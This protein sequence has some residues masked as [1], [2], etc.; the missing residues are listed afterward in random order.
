MFI[1]Y[2]ITAIKIIIAEM[3]INL[4]WDI[5]PEQESNSWLTLYI[6][7]ILQKRMLCRIIHNMGFVIHSFNATHCNNNCNNNY[8][9]EIIEFSCS[10]YSGEIQPLCIVFSAQTPAGLSRFIV[11]NFILISA[12]ITKPFLTDSLNSLSIIFLRYWCVNYNGDYK[13]YWTIQCW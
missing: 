10:R 3:D 7:R 4:R 12:L 9:V 6:P 13:N 2:L 8:S 11:I 1:T 5:H